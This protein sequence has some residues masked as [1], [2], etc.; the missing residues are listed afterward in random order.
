MQRRVRRAYDDGTPDAGLHYFMLHQPARLNA[1]A[2]A[3]ALL[4]TLATDTF[5]V[6]THTHTRTADAH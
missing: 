1:A 6:R 4:S 2:I 5:L 3:G